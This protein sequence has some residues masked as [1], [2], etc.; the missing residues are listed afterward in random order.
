MK[1]N[2][3][4]LTTRNRGAQTLFEAFPIKLLL[5]FLKEKFFDEEFQ[6]QK[7]LT[8][9]GGSGGISDSGRHLL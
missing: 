1:K 5:C 9:P 2:Q 4:E 6:F 8:A 3:T 7:D